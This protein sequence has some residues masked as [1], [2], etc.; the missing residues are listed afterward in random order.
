MGGRE[1]NDNDGGANTYAHRAIIKS[2]LIYVNFILL[3]TFA[4]SVRKLGF[5]PLQIQKQLRNNIQPKL[6]A[7]LSMKA[8]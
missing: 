2:E 5:S 3:P 4:N 6:S 7:L 1:S 8:I